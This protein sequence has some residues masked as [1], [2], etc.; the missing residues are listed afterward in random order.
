MF[1]SFISLIPVVA[2]F[3]ELVESK[4]ATVAFGFACVVMAT[5]IALHT[6]YSLCPRCKRAFFTGQNSLKLW[7]PYCGHCGLEL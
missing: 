5:I 7:P 4:L 6:T 3:A 2:G 1:F